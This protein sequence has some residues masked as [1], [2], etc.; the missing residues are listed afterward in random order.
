VLQ[1]RAATPRDIGLT[2]E[3]TPSGAGFALAVR[4]E[5]FARFVTIDDEQFMAADQGFCLVPGEH[6]IVPLSSAS[7]V[8]KPAGVVAALNAS[9]FQYRAALT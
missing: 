3:V 5:H 9:P 6:R 8:A 7:A 2:A 4:A 1:G